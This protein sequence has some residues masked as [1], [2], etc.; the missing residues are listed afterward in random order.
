[1]SAYAYTQADVER[2]AKACGKAKRT[3]D[4]FS[5]LCPAHDDKNPSCTIGVGDESHTKGP[6]C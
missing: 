4:E 2:I 6:N 5:C 3:G 1:M